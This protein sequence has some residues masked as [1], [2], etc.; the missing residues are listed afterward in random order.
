MNM[1]ELKDIVFGIGWAI[2]DEFIRIQPNIY[3]YI[4]GV[5]KSKFHI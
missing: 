2:L 4:Y 3:I 1:D 5:V